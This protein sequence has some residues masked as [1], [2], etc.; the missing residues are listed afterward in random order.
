[1]MGLIEFRHRVRHDLQA[2]FLLLS[3]SLPRRSLGVT[4]V[5][6]GVWSKYSNVLKPWV[7]SSRAEGLWENVTE[8]VTR[9]S[10]AV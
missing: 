4:V 10:G 3:A 6:V 7:M 9:Q 5:F 8:N 2:I 1:M